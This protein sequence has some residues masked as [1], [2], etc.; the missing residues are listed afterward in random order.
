M[1]VEVISARLKTVVA[2]SPTIPDDDH[3]LEIS[4]VVVRMASA[5]RGG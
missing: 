4:Q 5:N 3:P 1:A 2:H